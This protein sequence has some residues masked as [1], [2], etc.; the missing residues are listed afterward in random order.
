S[1]ACAKSKSVLAGSKGGKAGRSAGHR[2]HQIRICD[3]FSGGKKHLGLKSPR[4]F[5][6][7]PTKS[8]NDVE[9]SVHR[10]SHECSTNLTK[11]TTACPSTPIN[12]SWYHGRSV[13]Y[14]RSA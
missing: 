2:A 3:Q 11:T 13:G 12:R 5:S 7:L 10:G 6:P 14:Q 9:T 4:N 1:T 8:S